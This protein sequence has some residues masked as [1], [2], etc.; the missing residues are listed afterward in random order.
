[1]NRILI[2]RVAQIIYALPVKSW[3]GAVTC[4]EAVLGKLDEAEE[5]R[6]ALDQELSVTDAF[7]R[8]CKLRWPTMRPS[9]ITLLKL[10]T[11]REYLTYDAIYI[12]TQTKGDTTLK[13]WISRIRKLTGA[14]ITNHYGKGYSM[15]PADSQT[16][17]E[18]LNA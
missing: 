3:E 16:L 4:A 12:H 8:E 2:E 14:K 7:Y 11:S 18:T 10:L 17:K 6:K 15:A 9:E 5:Y 13:V 1:M